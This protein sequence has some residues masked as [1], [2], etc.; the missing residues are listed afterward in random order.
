MYMFFNRTSD[1][2]ANIYSFIVF[3]QNM[4]RQF[5]GDMEE[6]VKMAWKLVTSYWLY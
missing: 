3:I 4:A 2:Q 5:M 6:K 1:L